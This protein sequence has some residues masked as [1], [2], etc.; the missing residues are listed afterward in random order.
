M[1]TLLVLL[2]IVAVVAFAVAFVATWRALSSTG[3]PNPDGMDP[4]TLW[5]Y[6]NQDDI[7]Q[8]GLVI[9]V[10]GL[11]TML[12][13]AMLVTIAGAV[14]V[15]T[16]AWI[17]DSSPA[18]GVEQPAAWWGFAAALLAIAVVRRVLRQRRGA[19]PVS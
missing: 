12:V 2:R 13:P 7:R 8:V 1:R 16:Y 15:G 17:V 4:D 19:E 18:F 3:M 11:V 14:A 6:S 9:L 10:A 5:W